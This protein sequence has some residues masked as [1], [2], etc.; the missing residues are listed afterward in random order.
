[1]R[2]EVYKKS[3]SH[4]EMQL[5]VTGLFYQAGEPFTPAGQSLCKTHNEGFSIRAP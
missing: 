4:L 5:E 3:T 2:E 1:M